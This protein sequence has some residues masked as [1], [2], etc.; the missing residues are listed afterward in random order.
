MPEKTYREAIHDAMVEEM[1]RDETVFLMGEDIGSYGGAFGVS[2]GMLAEFGPERVRETPISELGIVG[3]A[4]GAA[5]VGMKPIAEMMF[6]DFILLALEPLMN[7]AAKA[8]YMFGGKATVPMVVRM[9]GGS[10][11]GAAAQHSQSLESILMAIPGIKVVAPSTPYDAKGLLISAIRDPNPVCFVEH[12][13]LY[14]V[15]GEV[16]EG[17]YSIPLG[18]AE[19]KHPG[20][21]LTV[22][23]SG[24]MVSKSLAVATK[25]E[26]EGISV[27]VLDLRTLRPMDN[28]AIIKSVKKTGRLLVVH[29]A[30][31]TGGWAGEVLAVVAGSE[32]FDYLDAPMRRLAGKDVPIPYNRFL[33]AAAVPQEA[34]IEAEIRAILS[35][36]Y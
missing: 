35:N 29:E 28:E 36:K 13:V 24:I 27:E 14:K 33:E 10:G 3:A 11:T 21:Q 16:P 9:A 19:I 26:A 31:Q 1:R 18:V 2:A 32:A 20:T 22:V 4:A 30:P 5:M 25:L 15:K 7:Q 8:R 34:D 23:S 12:K 17:E 6:M